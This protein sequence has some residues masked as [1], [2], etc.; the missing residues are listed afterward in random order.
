MTELVLIRVT[1]ADKPGLTA[2]ISAILAQYGVTIL[3]IGQAEIHDTLSLG[4]LAAIPD[5][6]ESAPVLK[7]VLFKAHALGLS[8]RFTPVTA[9]SYEH[10]VAGQGKSRH[11]ITLLARTIEADA[12][13][14]VTAIV[15][16][17]GLNIDQISRLSGR[18]PLDQAESCHD[19]TRACVEFSV[20][21][22]ADQ[23]ELR[24]RFL[25]IA[26]ELG[27]DVAFQA[28]DVY[29]RTRRL[30]AFDMDSTLIETEVIDELARAAGVGDQVAAITERAMQG[31]LD[32]KQSF[33]ERMA[34]LKGLDTR[35]LDGIAERL[36]ITEG[37]ER[38]IYNLRA[39]GYKTA[40]LS[41]GFNYFG[42]YLQQRLGI[43]YVFAN[44]LEIEDGLV[45]GRVIEPVVDGQRK[46]DLLR[47]LAKKEGIRL[48]QTIAV[49]DG[50]N[51]LPMLSIAGLGIAFRAK[52]LV[53]KNAR[54]S[55]STLGLDGI[56]YLL[57]YRDRDIAEP[58]T[59]EQV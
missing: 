9:E 31:E 33:A 58:G 47:E 8:I 36:P 55:I 56:L 28:D 15:A 48:E 22:E 11:I 13:A 5:S 53:R 51:D 30:V 44:E 3:D 57:G 46:A 27:V 1:G 25:D 37:A 6:A 12:I 17:H 39:L 45:T 59:T 2:S 16:E 32:F 19:N 24:A 40:I 38:L 34:L 20:R 35:V 29:R 23:S 10:W 7:D 42:R 43:D 14:S 18:V 52:P 41:G 21:G 4:I 50:A 49:G 54:N 26:N